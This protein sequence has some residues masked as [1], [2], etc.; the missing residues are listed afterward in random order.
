MASSAPAS[1]PPSKATTVPPPPHP[2]PPCSPPLVKT[3]PDSAVLSP[4][5]LP[6]PPALPTPTPGPKEAAA[7]PPVPRCPSAVVWACP[8]ATPLASTHQLP[9]ASPNAAVA[10][11]DVSK[12]ATLSAKQALTVPSPAIRNHA[13]IDGKEPPDC[14]PYVPPFTEPLAVPSEF[15]ID[16]MHFSH[17]QKLAAT[18]AFK[19]GF[20][21]G[22][23]S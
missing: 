13:I 6:G 18:Y 3:P 23:N 14:V 12:A 10:L 17:L 9:A 22:K 7:A 19:E 20:V 1:A 5:P 11:A 16:T 21:I 15:C 8:V 2:T 4:L